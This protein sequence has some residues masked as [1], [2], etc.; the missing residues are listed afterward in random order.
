MP[1]SV[2]LAT[3]IG[4]KHSVC[5]FFFLPP[6]L[7]LHKQNG[8]SCSNGTAEAQPPESIASKTFMDLHTA[9]PKPVTKS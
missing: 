4:T 8:G 1:T 9:T 6:R 3:S 2:P 7:A 5:L